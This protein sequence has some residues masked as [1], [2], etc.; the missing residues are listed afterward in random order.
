VANFDTDCKNN[1]DFL[2]WKSIKKTPG[3]SWGFSILWAH[4]FNG[5]EI[6]IPVPQIPVG[7][8][9]IGILC[10]R[11]AA[12]SQ[13]PAEGVNV[14]TVHQTPLCKV[15]PQRMGRIFLLNT[16]SGKVSLEVAFEGVHLKRHPALAGEQ[17]VP[18][19]IPV[20]EAHPVL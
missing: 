4:I 8:I 18:S 6:L 5:T 10:N 16:R 13:N 12:V 11:Y 3:I 19:G 15:I 17:I 14:H 9:Q 7:K 2:Q 1:H 20:F